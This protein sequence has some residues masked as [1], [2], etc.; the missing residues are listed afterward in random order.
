MLQQ[1]AVVGISY[2][3][4]AGM[5][6]F[7]DKI[8]P[9]AAVGVTLASYVPCLTLCFMERLRLNHSFPLRYI[10]FCRIII[11]SHSFFLFYSLHFVLAASCHS[12]TTTS[13]RG[14]TSFFYSAA[15]LA[16]QFAL[17]LFFC[18]SSLVV[19]RDCWSSPSFCSHFSFSANVRQR[20]IPTYQQ[21]ASSLF[22]FLNNSLSLFL[23]FSIY[24]P[25]NIYFYPCRPR[26]FFSHP[27]HSFS[28]PTNYLFFF[29]QINSNFQ[30]NSAHY[31]LLT[32]PQPKFIH[33]FSHFFTL[34][35]NYGFDETK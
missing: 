4:V 2:A 3:L 6:F 15:S 33:A 31:I 26:L 25:P 12:S 9:A 32:L 5:D 23:I 27:N 30:C 29:S 14:V 24:N 16:S 1:S 8:L 19:L 35:T 20:K 21:L 10:H 22:L 17:F 11:F 7:I 34:S 13:C 18:F 28:L